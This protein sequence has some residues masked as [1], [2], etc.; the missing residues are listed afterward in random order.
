MN[1]WMTSGKRPEVIVDPEI[2]LRRILNMQDKTDNGRAFPVL[3]KQ[4]RTAFG[5]PGTPAAAAKEVRITPL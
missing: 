3:K 4:H 5:F 1:N 2:I